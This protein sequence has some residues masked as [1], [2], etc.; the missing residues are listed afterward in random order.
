MRRW[1]FVLAMCAACE[2]DVRPIRE[3]IVGSWD[4]LCPIR[5]EH[6]SS[7]ARE[8]RVHVEQTFGADGSF[9][10]RRYGD[11]RLAGTWTARDDQV[12]VHVVVNAIPVDLRYRA[13]LDGDQLVLWNAE[14]GNGSI[15]RRVS[16]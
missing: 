9:E 4:S 3:A 12:T 7:C 13:H 14:R 10:T 15:L 2:R 16:P 1:L 11:L 5:D 8:S 6:A